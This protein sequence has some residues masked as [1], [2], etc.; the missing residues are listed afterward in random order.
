MIV[1]MFI[2]KRTFLMFRCVK[3]SNRLFQHD[4]VF[5]KK[6]SKKKVLDRIPKLYLQWSSFVKTY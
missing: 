4:T 6:I 3:Q 5:W 1:C 2:F